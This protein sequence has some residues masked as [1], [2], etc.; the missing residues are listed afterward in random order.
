MH[1]RPRHA[2]KVL[3]PK[4]LALALC[5]L[6]CAAAQ[7]AA[8]QAPAPSADWPARPNTAASGGFA[9]VQVAT[10]DATQFI[11]DWS[12][13]TP[14]ATL[15][16]TSQIARGHPI[17]TFITF[18]GCRADPAGK[19]NVTAS[20]ELRSPSGKVDAI[21]PLDVWANQP[22][23][24]AGIIQ[25]SRGALA[26]TFDATDALGVYTIRGATTDHVAGV[27]LVT[28]QEITVTN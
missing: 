12:K 19:C 18:R 16:V 6:A 11:K 22:Q 3:A 8:A 14:G 23:P 13:P 21:P 1:D 5:A 9:V 4:L 27:T 28:Q 26:M 15:Q 24:P 2:S 7:P 10:G 17:N 25:L 20:F